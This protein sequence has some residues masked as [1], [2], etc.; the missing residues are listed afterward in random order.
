MSPRAEQVQRNSGRKEEG[1][2]L[3]YMMSVN[4]ELRNFPYREVVVVVSVFD[5]DCDERS[6]ILHRD[7]INLVRNAGIVVVFTESEDTRLLSL[8]FCATRLSLP[9]VAHATYSITTI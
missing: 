9:P 6:A 2:E 8:A 5:E 7:S 4:V 3:E 1:Q